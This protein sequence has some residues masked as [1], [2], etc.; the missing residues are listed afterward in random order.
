M[1]KKQ[2]IK[3]KKIIT[4]A[5]ILEIIGYLQIDNCDEDIFYQIDKQGILTDYNDNDIETVDKISQ[6]IDETQGRIR[7]FL[8]LLI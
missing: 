4:K 6:W 5:I 3:I 1:N 7:G 8:K 2:E